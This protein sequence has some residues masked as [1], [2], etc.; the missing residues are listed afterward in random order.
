MKKAG[1]EQVDAANKMLADTAMTEVPADPGGF[2]EVPEGS[3]WQTDADERDLNIV[4]F[5]EDGDS[6]TGRFVRFYAPKEHPVLQNKYAMIGMMNEDGEECLLPG[7]QRLWEF[8]AEQT[9][10]ELERRTYRF[11]RK[12]RVELAGEREY[13]KFRV[14]YK[15]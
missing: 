14:Q 11:T 1:K 12:R 5:D 6:F 10:E 3:G 4:T 8:L 2:A 9:T 15:D 7:N 13:V